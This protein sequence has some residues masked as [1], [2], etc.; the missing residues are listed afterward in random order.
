[1]ELKNYSDEQ[2]L[3][4]LKSRGFITGLI[5]STKDVD[6]AIDELEGDL[7]EEIKEKITPEQKLAILNSIKIDEI[8][9]A[10]MEDIKDKVWEE[11]ENKFVGIE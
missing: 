7:L 1:M 10:I 6:N 3:K 2:L 9:D 11:F 5:L 4:E 8:G